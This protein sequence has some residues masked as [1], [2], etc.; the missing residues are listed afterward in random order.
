[1]S[2]QQENSGPIVVFGGAGFIGRHL[3]KRLTTTQKQQVI[4]VDS[5]VPEIKIDG[6]EYVT[7]DVRDLSD[8]KFDFD[9]PLIFNLAAVHTTPGHASWE[10]FDT[11]V[12]GAIQICRFARSHHTKQICFTSS[13][14]VY[15]PSD[16]PKDENSPPEPNS[17]YGRSKL[18]AEH[19]F[20]DWV[21]EVSERQLVIARPAVVFGAG[22]GGNFTRLARML[23]RGIF[24]YAG[25]RDT[26]KSC[27]YVEDLID[28]MLFA[29]DHS[30][31]TTLF[32]AAF[33]ERYTIEMIVN[34]FRATAFP[35][36]V[37]L[38]LPAQVLRVIAKIF[39]PVSRS[40]LGLHPER[41]DKLMRSTNVIPGWANAHSLPTKERLR[42]AL[43]QWRSESKGTFQ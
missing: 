33:H 32:N 28:W 29:I 5:F 41:I 12:N 1:M 25:R 4:S 3:L 21:H 13:I 20:S 42:P 36:V 27:I 17:D 35:S 40:G 16:L 7:H 18:I 24:I 14:S 15:G 34:A 37:T 11:N 8:L 31:K 38:T 43:E 6:V 30:E 2:Q 19:I 9:V 23:K 10:Y 26:I 39:R 22:E